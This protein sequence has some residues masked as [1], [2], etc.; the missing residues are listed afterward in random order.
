MAS[1]DPNLGLSYGWTLGE[2]GWHEGMDSNLK[3]L[4]DDDARDGIDRPMTD[5]QMQPGV[6]AVA[7]DVGG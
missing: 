1:V 2:S 7:N 4:T 3:R 5:R 6:I